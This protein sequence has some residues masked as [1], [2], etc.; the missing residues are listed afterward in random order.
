MPGAATGELTVSSDEAA[1]KPVPFRVNNY[2]VA[3]PGELFQ[4]GAIAVKVRPDVDPIAVSERHGASDPAPLA[5]ATDDPDQSRWW[6]MDVPRDREALKVAEYAA[7]ED[8]EWAEPIFIRRFEASLAPVD[9]CY[10]TGNPGICP[11]GDRQ[12][13]PQKIQA[14]TA[15]G[16]TTGSSSISIAVI[17]SGVV[18][19]EDITGHLVFQYDYTGHGLGDGCPT[20]SPG[21]GTH[22]GGIAAAVTNNPKGIAGI[23]WNSSI[24]SYKIIKEFVDPVDGQLKCLSTAPYTTAIRDAANHGSQVINMSFGAPGTYSQFEQGEI[25]YASSKGAVLVAAAGND[26]G[27]P[28][29]LP[30]EYA[31]VLAVS[32]VK[33]VRQLGA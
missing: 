14:P 28:F 29:F 33:K 32:R 7:D 2:S 19:H 8:V 4:P 23:G 9:P 11:V 6:R 3:E 22:V 27:D 31:N 17:D 10:Q 13:A 30:A 21:H 5:S 1:S 20:L 12:W 16:V 25:N 24:R 15:W 18:P 26:N